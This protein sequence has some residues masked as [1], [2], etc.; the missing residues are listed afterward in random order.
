MRH[1][2]C[3]LVLL[4]FVPFFPFFL[5]FPFFP[6]ACRGGAATEGGAS[7]RAY[8][9]SIVD[10]LA[11][12][13]AAREDASEASVDAI[14]SEREAGVFEYPFRPKR[15]VY[16]V[17]PPAR[18]APQRLLANLHGVCNPPGYACGYWAS[19][20]S[21]RGFLVCPTGNARCGPEAY[22]A[23]TWTEPTPKIDDDLEAA[24]A[25][26][27]AKY[28][29]EI[30]RDG[31]V[32]TGFSKGAYVAVA[33]AL[34]HPGRWPYLVLNEADVALRASALR[35][36]GVKAVALI[37]G[38]IGGQLAGERKTV[39][40]LTSQGFPAKL[41]VMPKAGHF[42]SANIDSI[43]GEAIDWAI[44]AGNADAH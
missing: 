22:E 16:V 15:D 19:A 20:A 33:I 11:I 29:G 4:F 35:A 1:G 28:P 23:P 43:M 3:A 12:A 21:A 37:A 5:F 32:L 27:L 10:A 38:E 8:D 30:A 34:R 7:A 14:G 40:S 39:L 13:D 25:A 31:A 2:L 44:E 41:W 9:A 17:V 18:G 24:I 36:A 6:A 26:V 42:Y